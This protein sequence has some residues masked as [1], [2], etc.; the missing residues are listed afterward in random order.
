MAFSAHLELFTTALV[1]G[2]SGAMMP[3][4]MFAA[5]V[6]ET[7]RT[8]GWAGP[9]IVGGHAIIESTVVGGLALGLASF[10]GHPTTLAAIAYAGGAMLVIFGYMTLRDSRAAAGA[11]A[12]AGGGGEEGTGAHPVWA[13]IVT[14]V[15]NPYFYAWWSSIGLQLGTQARELGNLGYLT[16]FCGHILAD[17]TWY[18]LVSGVLSRGRRLGSPRIFRA[19]LLACGAALVVLG[20]QFIVRQAFSPPAP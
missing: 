13:G 18:S 17:F 1:T 8:G 9:K 20:L 2:F 12:S 7:V 3:G 10:L 16:F 14:T 5:T 19:I 11:I 4:P 6:K 15:G